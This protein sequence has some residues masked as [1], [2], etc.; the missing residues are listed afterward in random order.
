MPKL[1]NA[2]FSCYEEDAWRLK[3]MPQLGKCDYVILF[4]TSKLTVNDFMI[5]LTKTNIWVADILLIIHSVKLIDLFVAR[6]MSTGVV[7]LIY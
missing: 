4:V 2:L 3:Y 7:K 5:T 1:T 6:E